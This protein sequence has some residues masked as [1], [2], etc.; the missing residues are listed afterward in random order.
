MEKRREKKS[1][2][3][4]RTDL[5]VIKFT[6]VRKRL[7]FVR[8]CVSF[9]FSFLLFCFSLSFIYFFFPSSLLVAALP[10]AAMRVVNLKGFGEEE[11]NVGDRAN[12]ESRT[13]AAGEKSGPAIIIT[14]GPRARGN[15]RPPRR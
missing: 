12:A 5:G 1:R 13:S 6:L 14:N 9:L 2:L 11:G 8:V 15:V 3:K 7:G 10:Y 4:T